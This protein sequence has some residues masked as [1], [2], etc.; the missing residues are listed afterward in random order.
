M[1]DKSVQQL[2]NLSGTDL[3]NDDLLLIW[4]TTDGTTRNVGVQD[5]LEKGRDF[6]QG[7]YALLTNFYFTGGVAT[8]TEVTADEIDTWLPVNF[9]TDS[10]GVFDYRPLSMKEANADP[11]D[12]ATQEF[13]LEGL[14]LAG[15]VNFRASMSFEPDEDEGQLEVRL[16]FQRH[17]GT[18]PSE[19]FQIEDV[20]LTM[21]QGA[22]VEYPAEPLLTFFVGDT[23]DTNAPGDAGIAKF[24]IRSSVPGT[25]RMR[26]LTWYISS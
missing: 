15:N 9:V 16:N 2:P 11:Y 21:S 3:S 10:Q 4:N 7:Y 1:S 13:T 22:D 6:N 19:N 17:S 18:T 5:V 26:A 8:E 14:T 24:E 25:V 12:D 20:A 23:I